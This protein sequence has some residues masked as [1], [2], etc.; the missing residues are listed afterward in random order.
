M[1]FYQRIKEWR[2]KGGVRL[3]LY[4]PLAFFSYLI[5]DFALRYTYRD[6]GLTRFLDLGATVGT[7]GWCLLLTGIATLI[8]GGWKRLYLGASFLLFGVLA[9]AH[10]VLQHLFRRFFMFSTLAFAGDG[11]AFANSQYIKVDGTVILG[12]SLAALCMLTALLLSP[13]RGQIPFRKPAMTSLLLLGAGVSALLT[14]HSRLLAPSNELIWDNF[15]NPAAVYENFT[16]STSCLLLGGLY[17]YTFRDLALSLG[18]GNSISA[19]EKEELAQFLAQRKKAAT[20]NDHTGLFQGKNVIMI[21]LE[22]IDTWM[23]SEEYMPNLWNL[24]QQS[25]VFENHYSPAYITAGTLNT[26]FLANTGL[27]PATGQ[28][29]TSVY[30]RNA[31]PFSLANM[32]QK[33]GYST[34]SFHGSEGNIYNR[35]TFHPAIGYET[36]HSGSDMGMEDYTMDR[37][38]MAGYEDMV[39]ESPFLSF[40]I[41]YSGHGPYHME[42]GSYRANGEL[43]HELVP[44]YEGKYIYA[45]AGAL[46][47]DQFIADLL[48]QLE[49]DGALENTILVFYADHYNY[50]MMNDAQNMALKG[51]D[52]MNLLQHTDFFIYSKDRAPEQVEKLTSSLD[53]LP[54]LLNLLGLSTTEGGCLGHDAFS[55]GGGYVFFADGSWIDEEQ[56]WTIRDPVTE[57]AIL[58]NQEIDTLFRMSNLIL[59]SNYFAP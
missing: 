55:D 29:S 13:G 12:V 11:L 52:T 49:A 44:E 2:E 10:S 35:G 39:R 50:Y 31:Y 24:K 15:S 25:M 57:Q 14:V 6:L 28:V 54:T 22:A 42:T 36:Y 20:P 19:E 45:V 7:L 8:P 34:Q 59:Q 51:V 41:T 9:V 37:C 27:I 38:L 47:T 30:Q 43:A 16:D 40:I 48:A 21:Q 4:L 46:E 1:K 23:L 32:L 5:L 33:A 53:I 18:V 17:D 58:R 26:E 56:Y 3:W